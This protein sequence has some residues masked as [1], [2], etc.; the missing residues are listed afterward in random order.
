MIET[1]ENGFVAI[2]LEDQFIGETV[3]AA[4]RKGGKLIKLQSLSPSED[5]RERP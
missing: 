2:R 4:I 1:D 3:V 5:G